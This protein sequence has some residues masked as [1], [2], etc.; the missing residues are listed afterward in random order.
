MLKFILIILAF[1]LTS[2]KIGL[3][4]GTIEITHST[5]NCIKDQGVTR[6]AMELLNQYGYVN[7][8]FGESFNN[9]RDG[10][11]TSIDAIVP[12]QDLYDPDTLCSNLD[13]FL[14]PDFDGIIWLYIE[15]FPDAWTKPMDQRIGF[16][17]DIVDSCCY[18]GYNI[19]IYS[20][21][22]SWTEVFGD[23]FAGTD[24]LGTLPMWYY[25]DQGEDNFNDFINAGFGKWSSP[26]MKEY[27]GN[28]TQ[29]CEESFN[30]VE[31]YE[32]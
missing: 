21:N 27:K 28:S 3:N 30:S 4:T 12:I 11:I 2:A 14:S 26:A 18:Y 15:N 9:L 13:R 17:E 29:V 20:N 23:P 16:L 7:L 10:Q 32:N 31:Y 24:K 1:Y 19:G 6:V 22:T 25:N 5:V 8:N